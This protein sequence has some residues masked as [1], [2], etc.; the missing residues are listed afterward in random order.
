MTPPSG[1]IDMNG[2]LV[3]PTGEW[4]ITRCTADHV[5]MQRFVDDGSDCDLCMDRFPSAA[6]EVYPC[7]HCYMDLRQHA[8]AACLFAPTRF[9]PMNQEELQ[10]WSDLDWQT[11][12]SFT[13]S[14]WP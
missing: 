13:G 6:P 10:R 3:E 5:T 4:L 1:C 2:N 14:K 7:K 8:D 11:V 12:E 9:E